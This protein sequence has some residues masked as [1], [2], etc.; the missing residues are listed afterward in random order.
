MAKRQLGPGKGAL[1]PED[2]IRLQKNAAFIE[3]HVDGKNLTSSLLN[4]SI[5]DQADVDL[6]SAG[7]TGL[8]RSR[9]LLNILGKRGPRAYQGFLRALRSNGYGDVTSV[10]EDKEA[11]SEGLTEANEEEI[12]KPAHA[13]KSFAAWPFPT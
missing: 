10:I 13:E 11:V 1:N 9:T 12:V 8:Q 4:D 5:I 6:V 3:S 7:K 2:A